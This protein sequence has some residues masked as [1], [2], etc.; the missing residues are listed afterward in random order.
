MNAETGIA[1]KPQP[2]DEPAIWEASQSLWF[3]Q[4]FGFDG[5]LLRV[6]IRRNAYDDQSHAHVCC[7]SPISRGWNHLCQLHIKQLPISQASY[8]SGATVTVRNLML[9]SAKALL[10]RATTLLGA[11]GDW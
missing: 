2:I 1:R 9:G 5:E 8:V 6:Q 3:E 7:W 10:L 4:H 11:R